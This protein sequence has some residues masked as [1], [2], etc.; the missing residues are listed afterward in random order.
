MVDFDIC[1]IPSQ[2]SEEARIKAELST[3]GF[4]NYVTPRQMMVG[5]THQAR[6]GFWLSNL[7]NADEFMELTPMQKVMRRLPM[8][9]RRLIQRNRRKPRK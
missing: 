4:T 8:S 1:K 2:R 7:P 6:I 5:M 9:I 3:A